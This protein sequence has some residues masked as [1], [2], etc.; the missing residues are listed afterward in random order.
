MARICLA[1]KHKSEGPDHK[2]CNQPD[3]C[4]SSV[5]NTFGDAITDGKNCHGNKTDKV[6]A[7]RHI[8]REE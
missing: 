1:Q 7:F 6:V 5:D 2:K 8:E 3:R 4:I